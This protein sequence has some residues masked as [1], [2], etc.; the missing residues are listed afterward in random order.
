MNFE[1]DY[2]W[3]CERACCCYFRWHNS[4]YNLDLGYLLTSN[5]GADDDDGHFAVHANRIDLAES[6]P[7]IPG[8]PTKR[9]LHS[10][11]LQEMIKTKRK[12][13]NTIKIHKIGN[14]G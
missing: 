12:E 11:H 6:P 3:V 7:A 4:A 10:I 8:R 14:I 13:I 1:W 9:G 2:V 5:D